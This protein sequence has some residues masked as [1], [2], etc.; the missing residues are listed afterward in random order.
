[1]LL[2]RGGGAVP[3]E[4]GR[5]IAACANEIQ[6]TSP[7]GPLAA[8][9]LPTLD[10]APDYKKAVLKQLR[11]KAAARARQRVVCDPIHGA[12]SDYL[13]SLLASRS[14][15]FAI[16]SQRDVQFGG[17]APDCT[18]KHVAPLMK[19]V[20][21]RKA[22]LGLAV[23]GDGERFGVVDRDGSFVPSGWILALLADYLLETRRSRLGIARST[24][25]TRLLD[26]VAGAHAVPLFEIPVDS[27]EAHDL[28]ADGKALLAC[29]EDGG[30]WVAGHL[31]LRDGL[32]A[33]CLVAEMSAARS[34][35]LRRLVD[36]LFRKTGPRH[37]G[38]AE[39]ALPADAVEEVQD[40]LESPPASLAGKKVVEL[41]R[42]DGTCF[43]FADGSWLLIRLLVAD[44][45]ARCH[46]E[47]RSPKDVVRLVDAGRALLQAS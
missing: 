31:P 21:G 6:D 43:R 9:K 42:G 27:T 10:P 30:L 4:T 2:T 5:R 36:E 34:K 44:S 28:F 15:V 11:R 24:A 12:A 41:R 32:L 13:P 45:L 39:H 7:A 17:E 40:R 33:A 47:A 29:E 38:R 37:S 18:E 26:D 14:S 19:E 8:T 25:T 35:P 3:A 23:D 22:H 1:M 20:R 46:A 16:R